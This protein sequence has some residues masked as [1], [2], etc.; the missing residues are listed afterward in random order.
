[1]KK[2]ILILVL[3][4]L[5]FL[6]TGC[7]TNY[8]GY[9]CRYDET[10]TIVILLDKDITDSKKNKIEDKIKSLENISGI[11]F[12]SKDDYE[13]EL[14]NNPD[15]YE[16]FVVSF[17]SNDFIGTYIEELKDMD[18]VFQAEQSNAKNNISLYNLKSWGKYSYTNSDE[19][20]EEELENGKYKI[21]KGI[22]TFTPENQ[23]LKEK[24]LY[25]KDGLLC[26][27]ADCSKIYARSNATCSNNNSN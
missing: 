24:M 4:N 5:T 2:K 26:W 16:T 19:A 18:G 13:E 6:L 14:G 3:I 1:M 9:W 27:D 22:I 8:K 11:N 15:I 20:K 7:K 12:Y 23:D 21:K 10:S 25:I 17:D